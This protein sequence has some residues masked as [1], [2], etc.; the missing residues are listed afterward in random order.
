MIY[1]CLILKVQVTNPLEFSRN[2][3]TLLREYPIN[4]PLVYAFKE[5]EKKKS[6]LKIL[7]RRI[8]TKVVE[9]R[10]ESR[11]GRKGVCFEAV[12]ARRALLPRS[13][14]AQRSFLII[15]FAPTWLIDDTSFFFLFFFFS[16]PLTTL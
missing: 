12:L 7:T 4:L 11:R 10:A 16:N 15:L 2:L 9:S 3:R 14:I 5:K 1:V 13:R 8:L 6:T